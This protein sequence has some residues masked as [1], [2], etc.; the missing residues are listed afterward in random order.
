MKALALIL[1]LLTLHCA[2]SAP[3]TK[4]NIV[5]IL[6]DD[7][8]YSDIGCYGSEIATPHLDAL[9][10]GGL[11][12][13]QFYN[14]ARCWPTRAALLTGYYAQQIHRDALP[15][16][17]GGVR[18]VRPKWA[19]LL[20][21]LLRAAGY[22]SYA[23]GKWHL[24]GKALDAGFDR[25]LLMNNPGNYFTSRGTVRDD[26]AVRPAADEGGY[27]LTAA[28]ADHAI[29]CLREHAAHHAGKPFFQYIAFHAPH[30]PL[31]APPE[32]IAKYH[33]KYLSGWDA[34]RA[35]RFARQKE[36][37]LVNTALSPLEREVGP[38]H[39]QAGA[40][41][42]LGPAEVDRPV[43]WSELTPEQRRFQAAKM[44]IHAAMVDRM[45]REIGRVIAQLKAMGVF[46]DT[47]ILF[48]SDNGASA[49]MLVR[50]G[51]HDAT[52]PAGSAA[53][54]LSLGPGWSSVSNTPFRRH[55][56]W[57]HE[58]GIA[59]PLIAHWPA[60]ISA[61]GELRHT[62][63]HVVDFVPTALALARVEKPRE[64]AG[65]PV[66]VAP[67]RSLL[68][69]LAGDV[70]LERASLWWLHEG[71]RAVRVGD[72]KL[73]A[74]RGGPWQLYDLKT[75]RAEQHDL[76][77]Q[78]PDKVQE[79]ERVW[80]QQAD[81]FTVLARKTAAAPAAV[82]GRAAAQSPAPFT[83]AADAAGQWAMQ[84]DSRL[85]NVLLI[86]DSISIGYTREVRKALLG[87]ANVFR[88]M[89][90]DGKSPDNCGDTAIGL[91]N[92]DRW[93][94]ERRWD[95]IHFNWGLWD[96]CY[97]HPASKSQGNRDKVNGQVS[98][99]PADYERQLEQ[100][101][102][103]LKATGARLIWASTTLVPEGE[104]GRFPGDDVK[105]NAIAARVMARHGIEV[106][107]LHALTRTFEP[108]LFVKPGDVH[109]T[110]EGS[111]RLATQVAE[112]IAAALK[113]AA[114]VKP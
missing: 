65:E 8:G 74:L 70:T 75:D 40:L 91:K 101:V 98:T 48:A 10:A 88:P 63:A 85:P 67:G 103:R 66:P 94:G 56:T 11:R 54:Y 23:S 60:G 52:A 9:A 2:H 47:L 84:V 64:I 50:D 17:A 71:H 25:A 30:F 38:P 69:A 20:P 53:T 49:E 100:L 57:V 106:N 96:L 7:L 104:A 5:F 111:Q 46:D 72:W 28:T 33:D 76:A 81:E 55:K 13:T 32:D 31:H 29:E 113:Q 45:D 41:E 99:T 3:A 77:T 95:V 58:G 83:P 27:Y 86:G 59:T 114:G 80:Q 68:P 4:P 34:V 12:F 61:R 37:G 87:R 97:R 78:M 92:I 109:F 93:L 15:Q 35:A 14:T 6:A 18:G 108:E 21:A 110:A 73:V 82:P 79:L 107:D 16:L 42:K 26:V 19:P 44:A 89:R 105:Y 24:D 112:K 62:P 1:A 102:T 39:P 22:R 51:G 43:P 36:M 90:T